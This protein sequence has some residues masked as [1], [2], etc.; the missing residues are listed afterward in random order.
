MKV[1]VNAGGILHSRFAKTVAVAGSSVACSK[2][3]SL[4]CVLQC[5]RALAMRP[6]ARHSKIWDGPTAGRTQ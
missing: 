1:M 5:R 3:A 2:E 4:R 6:F